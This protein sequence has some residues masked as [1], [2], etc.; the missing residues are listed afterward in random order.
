ML[1]GFEAEGFARF[2][3]EWLALDAL[4]GRAARVIGAEG[5]ID[6]IARGVDG[7]GALLLEGGG[8]LHRFVSGDVSLR[9]SEG[10]A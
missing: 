7:D 6:G 8:R 9:L 2:R 3:A 10:E 5:S 1:D 4:G